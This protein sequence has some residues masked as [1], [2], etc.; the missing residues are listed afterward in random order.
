MAAGFQDLLDAIAKLIGGNQPDPL[1][2]PHFYSGYKAQ[3]GSGVA[4]IH[5]CYSVPPESIQEPP[6]AVI[7]PGAFTVNSDK[8]RDLLV[9]GEEYNVDNL[10]LFLFVRN[11]D[12]K[13]Q[14][15]NLNPFR[16]LIP[17]VFRAA[18]QLGNAS[19]ISGQSILQVWCA[20]GRPGV[21]TYAG[22]S[23]IGWEY[24][25]RVIRML[26]VTYQS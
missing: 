8:A 23:L 16:D 1:T 5:G 7:L 21:F 24:T 11:N 25:L 22:T 9:Q 4:G 20:D 19:L 6:L 17:T 15:A 26:A 12:S 13:T 14:F 18:T 10:K 2:N 3:D